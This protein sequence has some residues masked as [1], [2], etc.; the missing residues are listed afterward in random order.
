M[1]ARLRRPELDVAVDLGLRFDDA[2]RCGV[3]V[4]PVRPEAGELSPTHARVRA[5][6]D[7]RSVAA[8][9]G[10]RETSDLGWREEVHLGESGLLGQT[11]TDAG[12][13]SNQPIDLGSGQ[14]PSERAV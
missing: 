3:E 12:R 13:P 1:R 2:D 5:G 10:A 4:E 8:L 7:Q 9:D 14:D 11:D 6:E